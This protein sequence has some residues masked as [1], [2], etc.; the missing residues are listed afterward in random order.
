MRLILLVFIL[1]TLYAQGTCAAP[2]FAGN[3]RSHKAEKHRVSFKLTNGVLEI[4]AV[5]KNVLRIRAARKDFSETPSYAVIQRPQGKFELTD[6]PDEIVLK[7]GDLLVKVSRKPCRITI[8]DKAGNLLCEDDPAFGICFDGDEVRC[9]KKL[10]P[11]E[12]FYGLGEKTG[13]LEKRG[14]SYTMWN[15]DNPAYS[16]TQDPL[17]CSIPFLLGLREGRAWGLFFDNTHKSNFNLGASNRRFWSF[18]AD[19]GELDY[20]FFAGPSV[21]RVVS[22]YADLTGRME[23]PPLWALGYQ[24]SK[25]SYRSEAELRKLS[26][27]FREKRIPCDV[28]YLDIDYMNGYRVFTWDPQ[29]F[30]APGRLLSD[31]RDKGF[32]VVPIIDPGVKAD[33]TYTV[34]AEGIKGNH[35]VTYPDGELYE[36][37]AWPSWAYFPDFTRQKTREWW[38]THL[39]SFL[40]T[41]V[42]GFW[43]DMNEP[44]VW[45][46]DIPGFIRFS[47]QGHGADYRK[48]KN[49]YALEMA[50]A[51]HAVFQGQSAR[52]P[53]ILTRAGFAGIQRFAAVWTGDNAA[54]SEH[55][56][57][58]CVML[59]GMGLSGLPFV[60]SDVGGFIGT[61]S[62]ALFVRWMQFGAFSPFFRGHN[63]IN[64]PDKEPWAFGLETERLVREAIELRYRLLPFFYTLFEEA[65]RTGL[66]ILRP[67]LMEFQDDPVCLTNE[68][69]H[70]FMIGEH[71]LVAPVL[72][73]TDRV[74][75]VYLPRGRWMNWRTGQIETGGR[76]IFTEAPLDTIPIFLREGAFLPQQNVQNFVGEE[77]VRQITVDVFP[78]AAATATLYEDEGEGLG[79]RHGRSTR[80]NFALTENSLEIIR[81]AGSWQSPLKSWLI[82]IHDMAPLKNLRLDGQPL[83]A[84]T[85]P[86]KEEK[87]GYAY[88][89]E[90]RQLLLRLPVLPTLK[91]TWNCEPE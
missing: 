27:T 52:R 67:M 16:P 88:D 15:S 56:A 76:W 81:A 90:R 87:P 68:C 66:P 8:C 70:Q 33:S 83:T 79:Y 18:G 29:R 22:S 85:D 19:R 1:L 37:E 42:S 20:Y 64:Q 80:T 38:G 59:Q 32:K 77:P 4:T 65:A 82:R 55:L 86:T 6:G 39:T 62:P 71:L 53:F 91:L 23:L 89:S 51:T 7:T 12:R 30:P 24:Q 43:N 58:G 44:A 9:F 35:F 3:V 31:L 75:R 84:L 21:K 74:K 73:E 61:P 34:A 40:D 13:N 72:N 17:Y 48:I 25:W 14:C 78:R 11:E 47:D 57:L 5:S 63:H 50:R 46:Q 10:L 60:G 28:I 45:G 36:A 2:I 54:T 49:V 26:S 69:Q 41:G